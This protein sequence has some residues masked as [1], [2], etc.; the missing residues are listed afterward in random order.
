MLYVDMIRIRP[1]CIYS[2]F[3]EMCPHAPLDIYLSLIIII[4]YMCVYKS[5]KKYDA[6]EKKKKKTS[7]S[8]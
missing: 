1:T 5:N 2:D 4:N 8:Y 7:S 6:E 3:I